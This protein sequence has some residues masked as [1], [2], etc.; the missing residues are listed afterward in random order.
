MSN[1]SNISFANS[2]TTPT[3]YAEVLPQLQSF[4]KIINF[5][6]C[7]LILF[8]G[9]FLNILTAAV[10]SR[11][12]FWDKSSIGFYYTLAQSLAGNYPMCR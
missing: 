9:W 1:T 10:F 6:F 11:K 5:Y 12:R 3:Y 2:S 7:I 4:Y 8:P